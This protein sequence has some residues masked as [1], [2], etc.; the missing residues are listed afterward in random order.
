VGV[1]DDWAEAVGAKIVTRMANITRASVVKA[2][3][4][5]RRHLRLAAVTDT[6]RSYL[7]RGRCAEGTP[8]QIGRPSRQMALTRPIL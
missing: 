7:Q 2:I 1:G 4:G 3:D 8:V 5:C 6:H